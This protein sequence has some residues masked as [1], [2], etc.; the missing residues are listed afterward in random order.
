MAEARSRWFRSTE[1]LAD[2]LSAPDIVVVDASWYLPALNRDGKSEYLAAH[3][4]GA[5][6]FD[7]DAIADTSSPLPHMLPSPVAFA[8]AMRRLGIGDGKTIVVYDGAGLFSAPRVWWTFRVFGVDRVFLLEG[9]LPKWTSEGRPVES[10]PVTRQARHFTARIDHAQ[11]ADLADVQQA[12]K[13]GSA[14]V[15]DARPAARFRG[16]APEPRPGVRAG[17]MP[18]S[19]NVPWDALVENGT[20]VD[21]ERSAAVFEANGVRPGRPTITSCGSGVNAAILW[22]A[23]D[24]L[25]HPPR[26]LYD[27]SWTEW[28]ARDDLPVATGAR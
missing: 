27:G 9:G 24:A 19:L 6:F 17:H 13:S 23:L 8:S 18:G 28:G 7:I 16:E 5:V 21:R 15:V 22:L 1:W 11:V 10:G 20:L 25:G 14:Q 26:A 3:I 2:H 12:I 4:P